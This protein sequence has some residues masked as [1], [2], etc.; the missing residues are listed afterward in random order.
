M[1]S[2]DVTATLPN[3]SVHSSRLPCSRMGMMASAFFRSEGVPE[4]FVISKSFR[5]RPLL[6]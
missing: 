5:S 3:T 6:G 1:D 4:A 2:K